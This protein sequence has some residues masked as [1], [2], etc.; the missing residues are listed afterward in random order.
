MTDHDLARRLVVALASDL[1]KMGG[2]DEH[3]TIAG[4]IPPAIMPEMCPLMVVWLDTKVPRPQTSVWFDGAI[5]IGVSWHEAVVEQ[6]ETLVED[7]DVQFALMDA[8]DRIEARVRTLASEGFSTISEVWQVLPGEVRYLAPELQE[9][10][11]DGYAIE[12]VVY[13]TE[14]E[15]E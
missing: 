4:R 10:L 1:D 15:A 13:A 2:L 9:G 12:V 14:G 11:V 7:L 8:L 3:N 6:A 5:S